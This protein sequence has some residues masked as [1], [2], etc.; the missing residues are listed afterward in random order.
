MFKICVVLMTIAIQP[1]QVNVN[2]NLAKAAINTN[3]KAKATS[4]TLS[5][6]KVK[7]PW[8]AW[9]GLVVRKMKKTLPKYNSLKNLTK[10]YYLFTSDYNYLGGIYTWA[11]RQDAEN[12]FNEEWFNT[13]E[14]KYGEKGEVRHYEIINE[15]NYGK[16]SKNEGRFCAVLSFLSKDTALMLSEKDTGLLKVLT[17]KNEMNTICFLSVWQ[18]MDDAESHLK[19]YGITNEYFDIPLILNKE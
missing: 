8:Y 17:L 14:R 13:T 4:A 11:S 3:V 12:W 15:I 2:S 16:P 9:R 1:F 6:T 19:K 10:K 5:I 7:M 18:T